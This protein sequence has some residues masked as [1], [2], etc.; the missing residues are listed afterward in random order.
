MK[1][2][3]IKNLH[4]PA[5]LK[6]LNYQMPFQQSRLKR[7]FLKLF[8]DKYKAIEE[9]RLEIIKE[10]CLKDETT[11]KEVVVNGQY[12]FSPEN[13]EKWAKEYADLMN[14]DCIID[15]P[16][17]LENKMGEVVTMINNSPIPVN[18][19]NGETQALEE[20]L[21]AIET[22]KDPKISKK[23]GKKVEETTDEEA[24]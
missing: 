7:S 19:A 23:P 22:L 12:Q 11:G 8:A 2:L 21:T 10:L 17:D 4:L 24:K 6:I 18:D 16:G 1:K 5:L 14:E 9:S 20:I 13:Q 15:I 3:T